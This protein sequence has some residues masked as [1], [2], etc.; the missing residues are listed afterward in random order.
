MKA[1][2]SNLCTN[3][4]VSLDLC[5]FSFPWEVICNYFFD[6]WQLAKCQHGTTLKSHRLV[7]QGA[8]VFLEDYNFG[9]E[10]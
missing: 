2:E 9:D 4:D 1:P 8:L 6:T 5:V 3:F 10:N 7:A